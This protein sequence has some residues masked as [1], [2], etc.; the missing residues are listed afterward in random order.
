VS[1]VTVLHCRS[2]SPQLSRLQGHSKWMGDLFTLWLVQRSQQHTMVLVAACLLIL[3]VHD[4]CASD[5][6]GILVLHAGAVCHGAPVWGGSEWARALRCSQ[7]M[8]A[9]GM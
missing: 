2:T 1:D 8:W 7:G 6:L 3:L 9:G 4:R 5:A